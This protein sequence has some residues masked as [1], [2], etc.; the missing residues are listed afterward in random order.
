MPD[1]PFFSVIV[2]A[3]NSANYIVKGLESIRMQTFQDYEL[4]VVCDSCTDN[5]LKIAGLYADKL[6]ITNHHHD[7]LARNTGLDNAEGKW[8]LFMDD[9]DW[10][11]HEYVFEQIA[12]MAGKHKED[13]LLFSFIWKNRGYMSPVPGKESVAVWN[14]C[15]R[16]DFIKWIRFPN[17]DWNT[18]GLFHRRIWRECCPTCYYWDMPMYYYNY[19]RPGS[20]TYNRFGPEVRA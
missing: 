18:D 10:F 2:P 6:F 15:W 20:Q 4:I 3:H 8:I 7:G 5:T 14:K 13:I 9:D 17:V 19:M 12:G 16:R 11:L 1:K